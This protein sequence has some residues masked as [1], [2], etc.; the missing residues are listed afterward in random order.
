MASSRGR[1]PTAASS[2]TALPPIEGPLASRSHTAE[3]PSAA[4]AEIGFS[5]RSPSQHQSNQPDRQRGR[6]W[7][8]RAGLASAYSHCLLVVACL[9][10]GSSAVVRPSSALL[11][12]FRRP[13]VAGWA[14]GLHSVVGSCANQRSMLLLWLQPP[15]LGPPTKLLQLRTPSIAT[16]LS[17]ATL[18]AQAMRSGWLQA[19]VMASTATRVGTRRGSPKICSRT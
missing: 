18:L 5:V 3:A 15:M 16:G 19:T 2:A 17:A 13:S 6:A 9:A 10:A 8:A 7:A 11:S 12:A 14:A 4:A 1:P